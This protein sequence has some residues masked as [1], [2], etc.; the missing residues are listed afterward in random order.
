VARFPLKFHYYAPWIF[1]FLR[2]L[3]FF[4]NILALRDVTIGMRFACFLLLGLFSTFFAHAESRKWKSK[5][6]SKFF[7]GQYLKHDSLTVTVK[8]DDG[9]VLTINRSDLHKEDMEYLANSPTPAISPQRPISPS[10][11]SA[12][13]SPSMDESAVF[14]TLKLGDSRA[15]VM[16]KIKASKALELT[17]DETYLG[18]FGLN[19]SYR[20]KQKI[21]GLKC[22]LYFDWDLNGKLKELTLQTQPQGVSAYGAL[23]NDNWR[24]LSKLMT[25]LHGKPLQHV[26]YPAASNLQND[27]S[28]ST[29]L[30]RLNTGGSALLGTSKSVEGYTVSVR[31]TSDVI[32]PVRVQP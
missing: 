14:D 21:G 31:F 15:E 3:I 5:D 7:M 32:E 8:R 18:R 23:L 9:R 29:H 2:F 6:G 13:T 4:P 30:W 12:N 10:H 1:A 20:T 17:V 27:M 22:L 16:S 11:R 26:D 25:T 19:G 24:E 28:L